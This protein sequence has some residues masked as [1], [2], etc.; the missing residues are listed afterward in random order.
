MVDRPARWPADAKSFHRLF[1]SFGWHCC[2]PVFAPPKLTSAVT[3]T[4]C[5][6]AVGDTVAIILELEQG[7][8][9]H[10]RISADPMR[11]AIKTLEMGQSVKDAP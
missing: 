8:G 9:G 6:L 3:L 1:L 7:F 11:Q 2:S 4:L 5:A 10:V